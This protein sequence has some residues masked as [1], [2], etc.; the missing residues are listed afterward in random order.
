MEIS[1]KR[2]KEAGSCNYCDR[3]IVNGITLLYPYDEIIEVKGN[4]TSTRFCKDCF[5][6]LSDF[7]QQVAQGGTK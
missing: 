7:N 1:I 2:I 6:R 5:K 3:G 4:Q